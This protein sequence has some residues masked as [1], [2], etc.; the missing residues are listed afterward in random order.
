MKQA[1][2]LLC[3]CL[4]LT[5]VMK[6]DDWPMFGH[7]PQR[8]GWA[9]GERILTPENISN[10]ELKWKVKVDNQ[11]SLLFAL[12]PPI[13][14]VGVSTGRGLKDVVYVAGKEG[15]VFALDSE[16]GELLWEWKVRK[17][18]LPTEIGL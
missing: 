11:G 16:T 5:P 7:D 18:A 17:Y 2:L 9:T 1:A 15:K 4:A 10:L 13:V 6:A 3:F 12:T 14:A 8:T